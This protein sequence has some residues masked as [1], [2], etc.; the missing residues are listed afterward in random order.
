LLGTASIINFFWPQ[1][2]PMGGKHYLDPKT[3]L[4]AG[5]R[6]VFLGRRYFPWKYLAE[7]FGR[8]IYTTP[9]VFLKS[10]LSS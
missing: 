9:Q 2:K 1:N 7:R 10:A 6:A 5:A 8:D 4:L 3:F